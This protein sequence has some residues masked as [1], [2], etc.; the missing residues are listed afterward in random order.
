MMLIMMIIIIV[1]IK[2]DEVNYIHSQYDLLYGRCKTYV[3][4]CNEI[5][6]QTLKGRDLSISQVKQLTNR[7]MFCNPMAHFQ[8]DLNW[9]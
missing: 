2:E 1:K 8:C 6:A 5:M 7:I 3:Q 9:K 4:E